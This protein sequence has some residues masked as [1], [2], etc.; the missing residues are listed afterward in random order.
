VWG[1]EEV[2]HQYNFDD[3]DIEWMGQPFTEEGKREAGLLD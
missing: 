1:V 2:G 3:K